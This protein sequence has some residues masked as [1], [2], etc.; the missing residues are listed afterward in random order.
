[1]FIPSG[2]WHSVINLEESIA[3]TQNFVSERNVKNVYQFLQNKP[4]K[5][6]F[7]AFVTNLRASSPDLLSRIEN[8]VSAEAKASSNMEWEALVAGDDGDS[9]T[10]T[11]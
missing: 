6:L 3:V 1:M 8:E 5:Q 11:F 9:W 4:S 10:L 7:N 2:W